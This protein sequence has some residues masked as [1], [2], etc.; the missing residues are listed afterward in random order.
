MGQQATVARR[1]AF[2]E[3]CRLR[4]SVELDPDAA[5]YLERRGEAEALPAWPELGRLQNGDALALRLDVGDAG[6]AAFVDYLLELAKLDIDLYLAPF[7][8][9]P[10]GTFRLW[11]LSAARLSLPA[12]HR[13]EARHD[14]IGIRLAQVGLGF[15][16]DTLCGPVEPEN[17]HLP[18]AGVTRPNEATRAGLAALVEHAGFEAHWN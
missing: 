14:L 11:A 5:A 13:V 17:R 3:R 18:V 6:A 2:G 8:K 15:G 16:A 1:Q 7:T 12:R 10:A 4:A 9:E